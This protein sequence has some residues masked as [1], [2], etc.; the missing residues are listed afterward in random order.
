ML[1]SSDNRI[2]GTIGGGL[3]LIHISKKSKNAP[4]MWDMEEKDDVKRVD[5]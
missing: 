4:Y 3:S 5:D 1:V 2:V